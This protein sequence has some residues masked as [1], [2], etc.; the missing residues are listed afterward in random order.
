MKKIINIILLAI[1]INTVSLSQDFPI[2]EKTGEICFTEIIE[3]DSLNKSDLYLRAREWF[4]NSFISANNV[5]Q[6]DN[7]DAGIIVGKGTFEVY[8]SL[9]MRQHAGYVHFTIKIYIKDYKYKYEITNIYH[10]PGA[11]KITTHGDLRKDKP[12]GGLATMGQK[13]WDGI[14]NQAFE[15]FNNMINDLKTKMDVGYFK[16]DW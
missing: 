14:R 3:V 13:N 10:E 7:K 9:L 8:T 15:A 11:S 4:A 1:L 2:D 16:D 6:M 5:I 12:G